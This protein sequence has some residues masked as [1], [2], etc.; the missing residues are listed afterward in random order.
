MEHPSNNRD[1][2]ASATLTRLERTAQVI[3][4]GACVLLA[5]FT[6]SEVVGRALRIRFDLASQFNGYLLAWLIFFSLP[7]VT[8]LRQHIAADF[9]LEYMSP[10]L[11]LWLRFIGGVLMVFYVAVLLYLCADLAATNWQ[12]DV[13]AQGILRTPVF[14]PQLGMLVGL[15]LMWI[16][17][18]LTALRDGRDVVSS[19]RS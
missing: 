9:L 17:A 5:L 18:L 11:R 16:V 4:I 1:S 19:L 8:R 3:A 13:R 7:A 14:Y 6:W 15:G 12:N 2:E 10:N